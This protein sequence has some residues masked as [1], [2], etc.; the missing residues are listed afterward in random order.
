MTEIR[1]VVTNRSS[2]AVTTTSTTLTPT[3]R[4]S[5]DDAL[6]DV[7]AVSLMLIVD[8]SLLAVGITVIDDTSF[9]TVAAYA[10]VSDAKV[11]VSAIAVLDDLT[12]SADNVESL[13]GTLYDTDATFPLSPELI[14]LTASTEKT[15]T[16]PFDND[17]AR[18]RGVV[19]VTVQVTGESAP[20]DSDSTVTVYPVIASPPSDSGTS[21]EN[22]TSVG[23][24]GSTDNARGSLGTVAGYCTTVAVLPSSTAAFAVVNATT[25][26]SYD[27]PFSRD[28]TWYAFVDCV[29][30]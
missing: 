7:T 26:K 28:C 5:D 2:D 30:S 14:W 18:H 13:D 11:G 3:S 25:W 8:A 24:A 1:Y 21:H 10:V 19:S 29:S 20:G 12:T 15:Y 6:P 16:A 27:V 23:V 17:D 9:E 22:S 4:A